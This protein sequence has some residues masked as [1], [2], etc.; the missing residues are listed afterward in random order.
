MSTS[1]TEFEG[2]W[3]LEPKL[4]KDDRGHFFESFNLA[5]FQKQTQQT[6]SFVQDNE[7]MSKVNVL[8]GL[9]FQ[10]SPHAQG[11]LVRVKSGK[12]LDVCVDLRKDQSTFGK[13]L[14]IELSAERKNALYIPPGFAHGF[15]ALQ[16]DT[17][18][19]YKC[20]AYYAP[21]Y[22][23][24]LLWNDPVLDIDW[25]VDAPILSDK[26]VAGQPF[27]QIVAENSFEP[28]KTTS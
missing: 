10:A 6:I 8:R 28:L 3:V 12:V 1:K 20:T 15:V 18:F 14:K 4:F 11:K 19:E 9:H 17:L 2:L 26:D 16:D 27:D 25:G 23:R 22:E 5:L 21:A 7:S 24:T 13:H